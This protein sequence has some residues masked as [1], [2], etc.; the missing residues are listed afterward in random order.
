MGMHRRHSGGW[1]GPRAT[2]ATNNNPDPEKFTVTKS[3]VS[4]TYACAL[5]SYANCTN[6][7]GKKIVVF[8]NMTIEDIWNMKVI[9]PHFAQDGKVI[10]RFRPDDEGWSD[11]IAYVEQK[12]NR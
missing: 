5:I 2:I 7:E 11:A 6:Y 4:G 3:F 10:A 1:D 12:A 8:E 9:D